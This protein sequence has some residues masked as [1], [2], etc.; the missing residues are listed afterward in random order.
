MY[1]IFHPGSK[2]QK[3]IV[4]IAS[5]KKEVHT[6]GLKYNVFPQKGTTMAFFRNAH[7]QFDANGMVV[8]KSEEANTIALFLGKY[9]NPF[10]IVYQDY[11]EE[12]SINFSATGIHYC[13]PDML[14]KGMHAFN[15]SEMGIS[16]E[17]LF[18]KELAESMWYL[19]KNLAERYLPLD[20]S[21][22]E[23]AI[24][25]INQNPLIQT[26]EMARLVF[27][28]EK[29]LNRQFSKYV[30]CTTTKYKQIV[31]F[32][33]TIEDYFKDNSQNLTDLCFRN[34]YFDSPHF[35]K[36]IRKIAHFTPKDFFR[37]VTSVGKD[38]YPYIFG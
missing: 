8:S 20:I 9:V 29:T 6:A 19:E 38:A 28:T 11:V 13:F 31:K 15:L 10:S 25:L 30:G 7:I 26:K 37:K 33:N 18:G 3:H 35:N 12:I 27:M 14:S 2:L 16:S 5:L 1:D 36:E 22:V 32:R 21:S 24:A 4:S 17:N 34:D 23:N